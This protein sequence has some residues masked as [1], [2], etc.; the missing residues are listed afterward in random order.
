MARWRGFFGSN[1]ISMLQLCEV[2][3]RLWDEKAKETTGVS[4]N[5]RVMAGSVVLNL[6]Q[7]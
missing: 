4:R 3:R 5:C 6:K 7:I 2:R 1:G